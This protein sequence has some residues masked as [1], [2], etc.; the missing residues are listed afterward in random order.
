M[1][2]STPAG[3]GGAVVA[4]GAGAGGGRL[5]ALLTVDYYNRTLSGWE[6]VVEPWRSAPLLASDVTTCYLSQNSKHR[7]VQIRDIV[8][9]HPDERAVA[10]TRA[11]GGGFHRGAQHQ[12]HLLTHRAGRAGA[13]QLDRGL[14]RAAGA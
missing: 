13:R 11:D 14:L 4:R 3:P 1:L 6:P 2:V 10:G 9:V 12:R 7:I 8:G 5:G